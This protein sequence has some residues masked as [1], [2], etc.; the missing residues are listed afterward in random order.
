[1]GRMLDIVEQIQIDGFAIVPSVLQ[2]TEI[3]GLISALDRIQDPETVRS[4]RGV[5]AIRDLL[6][7]APEIRRLAKSSSIREL[8]EPILG[9]SAFPVR[10]LLFDKTPKAN[11]KVP[12]HQDLSIPVQRRIDAPGFTGWS[13]KAGVFH[14]QPTPEI[15]EKMLTVRLHLDDCPSSNGALRVISGSHTAGRLNSGQIRMRSQSAKGISCEVEAGGALVMRPL[16]LHASSSSSS[17]A[18]R[19]VIHLEFAGCE[20]PQGLRWAARFN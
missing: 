14:V 19:R 15:Y 17:P 6:E 11:W 18:H 3:R 8:V 10:S 16:L 4:R 12:W 13:K 5:Y 9:N 20:L 1:M 7:V 2:P